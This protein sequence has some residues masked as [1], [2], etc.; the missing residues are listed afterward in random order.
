MDK[1]LPVDK[2]LRTGTVHAVVARVHAQRAL[3]AAVQAAL[4]IPLGTLAGAVRAGEL[5]GGTLTLVVPNAALAT[6]LRLAQPAVVAALRNAS[7]PLQ[8]VRGMQVRVGP[9]P[10]SAPPGPPRAASAPTGPHPQAAH[11]LR[12]AA[13][14][15]RNAD[16]AD[17][18]RRLAAHLDGDGSA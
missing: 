14:T 17:A 16:L 1:P 7:G 8:D 11:A 12:G 15:L 4:A 9:A 2:L 5:R 13:D 6:R 18:V 3:E 10:A